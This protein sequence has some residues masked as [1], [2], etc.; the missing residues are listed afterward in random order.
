MHSAETDGTSARVI[1]ARPDSTLGHTL[2]ARMTSCAR[3]LVLIS[4]LAGAGCRMR[5]EEAVEPAPEPSPAVQEIAAG[6]WVNTWPGDAEK[7]TLT[8]RPDGTLE[9]VVQGKASAG[10]KG[11]ILSANL[12]EW[13]LGPQAIARLTA[14]SMGGDIKI[15]LAV[16]T[17]QYYESPSQTVSPGEPRELSFDLAAANFMSDRSG[18]KFTDSVNRDAAFQAVE[19]VLYPVAGAH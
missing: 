9:A 4:L 11:A 15:A 6:Q 12:G 10:N 17:D 8:P 5:R 1:R 13:R 3:R 7:V 18:W 19:L 14:S 16:R 2:G